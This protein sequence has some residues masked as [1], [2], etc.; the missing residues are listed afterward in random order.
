MCL[1]YLT[2]SGTWYTGPLYCCFHN[3][4][5]DLETGTGKWSNPYGGPKSVS[6]E[7]RQGRSFRVY[8]SL[9]SLSF[10]AAEPAEIVDVMAEGAPAAFLDQEAPLRMK[11]CT[12]DG[13]APKDK[14]LSHQWPWSCHTALHAHTWTYHIWRNKLLGFKRCYFCLLL[15][16]GKDNS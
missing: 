12:K 11:P 6:G 10:L 14:A 16:A 13:R 3:H 8:Y 7:S 2:S 5:A 4:G 9:P 1:K 15:P